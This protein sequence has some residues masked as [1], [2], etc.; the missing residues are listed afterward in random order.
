M[1]E[2][3][4]KIGT[5]YGSKLMNIRMVAT[6][7]SAGEMPYREEPC[8]DFWSRIVVLEAKSNITKF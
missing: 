5:F 6:D 3:R 1:S 4:Q 8:C 7:M 2:E